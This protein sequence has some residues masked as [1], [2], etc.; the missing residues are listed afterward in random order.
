M[1]LQVSFGMKFLNGY[2]WL[3][4]FDLAHGSVVELKDEK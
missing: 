2:K 4:C 1:A 3:C